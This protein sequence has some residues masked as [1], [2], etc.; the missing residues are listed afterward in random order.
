V[1]QLIAKLYPPA[2]PLAAEDQRAQVQAAE[3][4]LISRGRGIVQ[5]LQP[6]RNDQR[7]SYSRADG[8]EVTLATTVQN[9]VIKIMTPQLHLS[10]AP[11]RLPAAALPEFSQY[12]QQ[13]GGEA[14]DRWAWSCSRQQQE[15]AYLHWYIENVIAMQSQ[16]SDEEVKQHLAP[17][18]ARVVILEHLGVKKSSPFVKQPARTG[19]S[20]H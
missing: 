3:K 12:Y 7:F 18:I 8:T 20:D 16:F 11:R 4:E 2:P 15:L 6:Y 5:H 17:Y 19:P 14:Y 13:A 10:T 1:K 9:I